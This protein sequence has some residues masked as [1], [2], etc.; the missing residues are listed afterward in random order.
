MKNFL[1]QKWQYVLAAFI[2]IFA[3]SAYIYGVNFSSV[4]A[5]SGW[6]SS[7]DGGGGGGSW[8]SSSSSSDWSSSSWSSSSHSSSGSSSSEADGLTIVV[9]F[10][11]IVILIIFFSSRSKA[12]NGGSATKN[13]VMRA[14]ISEEEIKKLLP[15]ETLGSLKHMAFE[16]FVAI[17]NAWMEFDYDKL[18]ELCTDELYNTYTSQ[19]DTL[20]IKNGKNV[21]SDFDQEEIKIIGI[22]KQDKLVT[23]EVYLRITFYDY[24]INQKSKEVIRGTKDHKL[25]NNY[26][27]QFVRKQDNSKK[28]TKC[29]NCGAEI[30]TVTS[31]KCEY[32]G[33]TIVVDANEFVLSKKTNINR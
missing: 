2:A 29:P 8:S 24:V 26:E 18:R 33:S 14:D 6:D 11:I 17:Q 7:Y 19:L 32:C 27:M 15:N 30:D 21:M 22:K 12:Q 10:I 3:V 5:D 13:D 4:R 1:K 16:N 20:K 25:T 9:F 23:V 28:K 31:T